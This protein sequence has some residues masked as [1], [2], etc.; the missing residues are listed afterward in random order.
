MTDKQLD[1]FKTETEELVKAETLFELSDLYW[2]EIRNRFYEF[3]VRMENQLKILKL[4]KKKHLEDF[5]RV[6]KE[7]SLSRLI[8]VK[9][10]KNKTIFLQP[11]YGSRKLKTTTKIIGVGIARKY[12]T[13][14]YGIETFTGSSR[15]LEYAHFRRWF[16]Q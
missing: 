6:R 9:Y 15:Y 8:S 16:H 11:E 13:R 14:S 1:S 7:N 4:M 12:E 3:D 5:F 10:V 2:E